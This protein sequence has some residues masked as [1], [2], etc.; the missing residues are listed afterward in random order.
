MGQKQRE[1]PGV[2]TQVAPLLH[3]SSAHSSTSS[4]HCVPVK[5]GGQV[6]VKPS[7]ASIHVPPLS[8]ASGEQNRTGTAQVGPEN[9]GG[10]EHMKP[11]TP[12]VQTPLFSHG[13]FWQSSMLV[14]QSS[15]VK[16]AGHMH[17][18]DPS[19]DPTQVASLEQGDDTHGEITLSH[20]A[21]S[22][23]LGHIQTNWST[24]ARFTK[25][26]PPFKQGSLEHSSKNWQPAPK[27]FGWQEQL[28]TEFS[29]SMHMPLLRQGE[30]GIVSQPRRPHR[31]RVGSGLITTFCV[32]IS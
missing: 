23:P 4:E 26:S 5:P 32:T 6:H 15:P 24:V 27:K 9:P 8:H 14:R 2:L 19:S 11:S 10:H 12:S 7:P 18:N 30:C 29:P 17:T 16:P 21:P 13:L 22:K 28:I 25:H 20:I 1:L 31:S 3:G